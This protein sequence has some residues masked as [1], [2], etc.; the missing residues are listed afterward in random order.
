MGRLI[1]SVNPGDDTNKFPEP[2]EAAVELA[3]PGALAERIMRA[4]DG[5][6]TDTEPK[7]FRRF[8]KDRAILLGELGVKDNVKWEARIQFLKARWKRINGD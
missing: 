5:V 6:D 3:I 4:N 2:G 7:H 1:Q 8:F